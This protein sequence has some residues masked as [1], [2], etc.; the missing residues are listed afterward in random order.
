MTRPPQAGVLDMDETRNPSR[1]A[2]AGRSAVAAPDDDWTGR[3]LGEFRV[4]RLIGRGG[5]GQVFLAEQRSLNR[6]VAVK[7]LRPELAAN[8]TALERFR[9]EA[10]AVAHITHA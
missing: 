3:T 10:R 6:K 2:A 5:M 8:P 4:L 9:Q 1:P 7:I